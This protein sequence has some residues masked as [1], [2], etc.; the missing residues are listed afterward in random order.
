MLKQG[1]QQLQTCLTGLESL[2]QDLPSPGGSHLLKEFAEATVKY[3]GTDVTLNP[4]VGC[5][6]LLGQRLQ[7]G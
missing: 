6:Q 5:E 3:P 4:Q 2:H 7:G 1:L